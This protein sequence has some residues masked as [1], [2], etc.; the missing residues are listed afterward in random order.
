MFAL[1]EP[2][3]LPKDITT[4]PLIR[5]EPIQNPLTPARIDALAEYLHQVTQPDCKFP[6]DNK[7]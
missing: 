4:V 6:K 1:T 7:S 2:T 5:V 3:D